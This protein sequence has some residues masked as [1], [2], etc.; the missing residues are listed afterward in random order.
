MGANGG[1]RSVGACAL[2][3]SRE[4][5]ALIVVWMEGSFR[6]ALSSSADRQKM[7]E[8]TT[9]ARKRNYN[10]GT[11]Q[12]RPG[13]NAREKGPKARILVVPSTSL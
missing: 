13:C 8:N 11:S 5:L 4:W 2:A 3:G 7:I 12:T 1:M 10:M 6:F 9:E